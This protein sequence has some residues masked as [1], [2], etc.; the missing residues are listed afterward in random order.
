MKRV[1]DK[2][3]I[4]TGAAE[5]GIGRACAQK[6][7]V[8]GAKV[9]AT[10]INADLGETVVAD[11]KNKGG[12]ATFIRADV[13]SEKD[14]RAV[15]D[16]TLD[17]YGRLDGVVNNAGVFVMS[18]V[19]EMSL[20]DFQK[21]TDVNLIGT[22]LGIK[23]ASEAFRKHAEGGSIVNIASI[24]SQVGIP[25]CAGYCASKG[26]VK[27]LSKA[28]ALEL[29]AEKIRVNTVHPGA[30]RTSLIQGIH[31]EQTEEVL[32]GYADATPL[33]RVGTPEEVADLVLFLSSDA[34]RFATGAE[35]NVD[36]GI[37]TA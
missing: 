17:S 23:F 6:L 33:G 32:Q 2:V 10:D 15:I 18:P 8:E 14:W 7:A 13:T 31:G 4:V 26:G 1:A 21:V 20:T 36:G 25:D 3:I 29:G 22:F 24:A 5:D 34:S 35:F 9:V 27:L 30:I 16:E 28:A 19:E 11:I 12:E 37:T